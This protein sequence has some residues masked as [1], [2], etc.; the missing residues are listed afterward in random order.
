[1]PQGRR[2]SVAVRMNQ[3]HFCEVSGCTDHRYALSRFCG[4]HAATAERQG[5]P[6]ARPIKASNWAAHKSAIRDLFAQNSNHEGLQRALRW[7]S[8]WMEQAVALDGQHHWASEVA[9]IKR[10]GV[11][12][13]EVLV[14]LAAA[15]AFLQDN[16]RAA[17][18]DSH[19]DFTLSRAVCG[20]APRPRT[21]TAAAKAK[22]T[23]GYAR[24]PKAAALAHIGPHLVR[25]LAPLLS[26]VHRSIQTDG[27]RAQAEVD[28]MRAPF[29]TTNQAIERA[30]AEATTH[31]TTT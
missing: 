1:M 25:T 9:R 14:E 30:A 27:Q 12:P 11:S 4:L 7:L 23:S 29:S 5:H 2:V 31:Q 13:L 26:N 28:A 24:Q 19:R 10:H 22:G 17:M 15:F 20:L 6:L 21:V 16:P 8:L 3:A 18:S